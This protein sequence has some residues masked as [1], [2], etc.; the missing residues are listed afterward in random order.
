MVESGGLENRCPVCGTVG[1]NPTLSANQRF[2]HLH[3]GGLVL[4]GKAAVLKTAGF[5]TLGGSSPSPSAYISY[6]P[7]AISC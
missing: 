3:T 7:L 1:S 2:V 6:W 5:Y 4:I